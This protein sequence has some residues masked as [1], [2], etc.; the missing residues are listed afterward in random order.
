[1]DYI[2]KFNE[3]FEDMINDLIQVFPNDSEFRLYKMALQ[4]GLMSDN[5]IVS[6]FFYEKAKDM[7]DKILNRDEQFFLDK[8]YNDLNA[9]DGGA[10]VNKLKNCWSLLSDDNKDSVWKYLKILVL[11]NKKIYE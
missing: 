10:I 3:T 9:K 4:A 7:S 11:L 1:M 6:K 8:D 2:S 5:K